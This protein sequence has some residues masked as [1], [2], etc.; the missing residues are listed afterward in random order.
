M[1]IEH[2]QISTLSP[3]PSNPRLH[4]KRQIR[5]IAASIRTFG[6][7]VPILT[8]ASGQIIAG[9][10]RLLAAQE[11]G[12]TQV[13]TI[14]L[15]HLSAAQAQAFMIADNRLNENSSWDEQLLANSLK[16]LSA[17]DLDFEIDVTGFAMGEIDV[18]IESLNLDQPPP[19]SGD[20]A[21]SFEVSTA[22]PV[23]QPSDLWLLGKHRILCGNSLVPESYSQLMAGKLATVVFEDPPYN[24][25]IQ[26]HV[27]GKGKI[28]H[29]EFAMGVGEMSEFEFIA[30]LQRA[31]QLASDHAVEGSIHYICMD[32]RH[33]REI[34]AAGTA[35]YGALKNLCVWVKNVGGM[36]SLYRSRHELIFVFKKGDA[37]HINNVEL[38][39]HGR[40]RTNVWE[41]KSIVSS[42]FGTDEGDL[43]AMHPTV[44]PAQ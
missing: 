26:G 14:S 12:M 17:L 34:L 36:G 29:R 11:L 22:S 39:R 25:P 19:Q 43:L 9:H 35:V 8:D 1:Q 38:G 28:R 6:F 16:E 13:P 24:V 37:P 18:R 23:T 10:G 27:G 5:Q 33:L 42:R 7:N 32:F 21:D 4:S 31:L 20:R 40:Y 3:S 2:R 41:H 30:F 44:K 15:E